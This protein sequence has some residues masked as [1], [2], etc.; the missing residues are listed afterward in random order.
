MGIIKGF[1][2]V[3]LVFVDATE[4][5]THNDDIDYYFFVIPKKNNNITVLFVKIYHPLMNFAKKVR[6]ENQSKILF[7]ETIYFI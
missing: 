6:S 4:I 7:V 5:F 3:E 1:E 2:R